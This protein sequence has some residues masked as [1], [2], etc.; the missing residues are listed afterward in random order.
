MKDADR[1]REY[2][3]IYFMENIAAPVQMMAGAHDPRCPADETEQAAAALR[4]MG[5]PHEV[6]IY[7]D[8]GH[9]FRKIENRIDAYTRRMAFLKEHLGLAQPKRARPKPAARPAP[10]A[11]TNQKRP[12]RG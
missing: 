9:G 1:Y 7:P 5:V 10:K 8:E 2:S 12:R 4:D 6:I 11:R 3:P